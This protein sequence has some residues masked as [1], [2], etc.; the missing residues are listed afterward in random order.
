MPFTHL[1]RDGNAH[2]VDVGDKS[3][4][5]REAVASARVSFPADVYAALRANGGETRKGSITA[6]AQ[7]AGIMAAKQTANL[8]PLCHPLPLAKCTID[9]ALEDAPRHAVRATA[10]VK[11]TG[12]T[13]VEMEALHAVSVALLTIYDMCKALDKRMEITDIRL[14]R[15]SGGKSGTFIR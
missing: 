9:F 13:G 6:T 8:I 14:M 3:V 11:V 10:T 12:E 1:D 4:S 2:M 7:I 15:K 5:R